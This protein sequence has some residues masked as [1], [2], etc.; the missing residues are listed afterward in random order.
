[1]REHLDPKKSCYKKNRGREA[2]T[3]PATRAKH[4]LQEPNFIYIYIYIYFIVFVVFSKEIQQIHLNIYDENT[5]NTT[6]TLNNSSLG[7]DALTLALD[8][9]VAGA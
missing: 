8:A 9:P 3:A 5:T 4:P 6:N 2:P 7:L 1:M